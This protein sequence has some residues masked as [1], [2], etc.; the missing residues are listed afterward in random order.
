MLRFLD[1]CS[2][3][4]SDSQLAKYTGGTTV[5][6]SPTG[7]RFGGGC[8]S[9]LWY[10]YS[11][12]LF[13]NQQVWICGMAVSR[14]Q[15]SENPITLWNFV[16][17]STSQCTV[18]ANE[19]RTISVKRGD[20][21]LGTSTF[22]ASWNT[23]YYYEV[24]MEISNNARVEIRCEGNPILILEGVDTQTTL[25]SYANLITLGSSMLTLVCDIYICDATG[26]RNND[27]LGPVRVMYQP[28]AGDG[29][30]TDFIPSSGVEPYKM[31]DEAIANHDTDYVSSKVAGDKVS[32]TFPPIPVVPGSL[33]GVQ[34]VQ[35]IRKDSTS[36][37]SIRPFARRSGSEAAL[38]EHDV[39]TTYTYY[40]EILEID[41]ITGQPW[42]VSNLQNTEWGVEVTE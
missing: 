21:V 32:F 23:Y 24:R 37:R 6:I 2:H 25:N 3:Y 35:D 12:L 4:N 22:V 36:N 39:T 34:I 14:T 26:S 8:L 9:G 11:S 7:G 20:T 10:G 31:V 30:Y 5:S 42:T 41:P 16:D 15:G 28:P 38:T 1:S 33:A 17:G 13:D 19:D 29:E 40:R 27:L 18:V